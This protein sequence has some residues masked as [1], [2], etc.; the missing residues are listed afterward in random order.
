MQDTCCCSLCRCDQNVTGAANGHL[1]GKRHHHCVKCHMCYVMLADSP[2]MYVLT[3]RQN[4]I[5]LT[6]Q[7]CA[8]QQCC[9]T[10][11]LT[12]LW[13]DSARH[14]CQVE[15]V[16]L[17]CHLSRSKLIKHATHCGH[18]LPHAPACDG[19]DGEHSL[20]VNA[21]LILHTNQKRK[22]TQ[23][24]IVGKQPDGVQNNSNGQLTAHIVSIT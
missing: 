4:I 5:C 14:A 6:K 23:C 2:S 11:S 9:T 1:L 3:A 16:C 7:C 10:I 21:F 20:R 18:H 24:C 15:C 17:W 19:T 13:V 12:H 22:A 8:T